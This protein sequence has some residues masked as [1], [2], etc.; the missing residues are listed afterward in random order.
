MN[1]LPKSLL[2]NRLHRTIRGTRKKAIENNPNNNNNTDTQNNSPTKDNK[3]NSGAS[4]MKNKGLKIPIINKVESP[5]K[6]L[7]N[8][9]SNIE[10]RTNTVAKP[11]IVAAISTPVKHIS[12]AA[13]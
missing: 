10:N 1:L 9:K 13:S 11:K 5:T 7:I 2:D 6:K 12:K 8:T 4:P 3:I